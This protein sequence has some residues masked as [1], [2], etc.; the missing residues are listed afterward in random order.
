M[1]DH[2]PNR[3]AAMVVIADG[4]W[5]DDPEMARRIAHTRHL[6]RE[7]AHEE[8]LAYDHWRDAK[9]RRKQAEAALDVLIVEATDG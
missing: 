5:T 4:V 8:G 7:L 1:C 9:D 3:E 2:S 6:I